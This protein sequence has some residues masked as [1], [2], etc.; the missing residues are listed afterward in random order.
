M[1]NQ[2]PTAPMYALVFTNNLN[3]T[4]QYPVW[5]SGGGQANCAV[6]DVPITS[7]TNCFTS[8]TFSNNG[9]IASPSKFPPSS[10]PTNNMFPQTVD[11]VQFVNYNNGSGGNYELQSTSPYKNK[12]TD[13]KDLGADIVGLSEMLANVQ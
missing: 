2:I 11:D 4:G 10:W 13:G 5:N 7:I 12:G 9:L 3:L 1:G 8:Y 6:Q